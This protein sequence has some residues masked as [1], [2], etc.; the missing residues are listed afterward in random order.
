M[1]DQ[2]RPS[3]GA[4]AD[5]TVEVEL[6]NGTV[7]QVPPQKV[8]TP[9]TIL[10]VDDELFQLR[11]KHVRNYAE[12]FYST[13][14]DVNDP[15]FD[16]LWDVARA[17]PGLGAA[18][19]DHTAAAAYFASDSAVSEVLLSEEFAQFA[20]GPLRQLLAPFTARARSVAELKK[21][22]HDAFQ[23]PEFDLQFRG[24]P[25]PPFGDV[26]QC[27]AVFLDLFLDQGEASPVGA[28]QNYLRQLAT[29]AGS[30]VLPPL[31]L[32]SSHPEL[33]QYKLGFSEH[34]EI[35]AAGLMVL[36]KAAL[37]RPEFNAPGLKLA[38]KQLDRQK[39]VA[40]AMRRFMASWLEAIDHAKKNAARTL[41][42]LDASA[43]QQIH[44][45][46]ISDDDPYDE[47]LNEFLSRE[48]LFH[49]E[50][51][52]SVATSVAEL[53][54][55][56]RAQL[57]QEGQIEN[58]LISPLANVKAARTLMSHFTWFGSALPASFMDDEG[59]AAA[60]IS[61]SL[62]FGCVLGQERLA[63]G[64][65]CLI[66]ITQQCD[67]N[68]I[69]RSKDA[70][71]TLIFATSNASE[72]NATSNPIVRTTELV[73]KNLR[74]GLGDDEREFD[75]RLNVGEVVAMPLRDFLNKARKEEWRVIGRLRSDITNHIVAA[76][77]NH[78][79]RPA[80]QKMIR[81]GLLKT[82]VFLQ[83]AVFKGHQI[84][85]L[86]NDS[87]AARQP[88]KVFSVSRDEER[89]SFENDASIEIALWLAHHSTVIGLTLDPDLLSAALRRGWS[90]PGDLPGGLKV[91]LRECETLGE[92]Y[93]GVVR[94]D[95]SGSA[96]QLTIIS[97]KV[98]S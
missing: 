58:R 70:S 61:R 33:E 21:V 52:A 28:L 68:A 75:L 39:N 84:A 81:P 88:A 48:H 90:S 57:D 82:K 98:S 35:S 45:A 65:K 76:T 67:L 89:Y 86:D 93:K 49:I 71:R 94:G 20:N 54:K 74:I 8:Q 18:E 38:F 7:I 5:G 80:S 83:S 59:S 2:E 42:N 27:A 96:V 31:V 92:A 72:L 69:S 56:F 4:N 85:L 15:I 14:E 60:R 47:H 97:E 46:S 17:I 43:M 29:D 50:S 30:E 55:Q 87:S 40:H 37:M 23:T 62:P 91:R 79:S 66:H 51:Q 19:W 1:N 12:N 95:I 77:T 16:N 3:E 63:E 10:V 13:I 25:R 32:M 22:F 34:A 36:P 6:E 11:K 24:S 41:W 64:S 78:M 9:K 26:A 73:A 44:F 53:D